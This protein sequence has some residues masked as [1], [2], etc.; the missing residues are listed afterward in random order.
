MGA[1]ITEID[2]KSPAARAKIRPGETLLAINGH[3][4]R[5]VLDY[6]FYA[7]DARLTLELD[8]R[9]VR[10]RKREGEDL[11]LNFETYLMD[12]KK[13]CANRCIF[14][15]IDQLPPGMRETL[16][17][18]D[19]DAR[20]SFLMGNYISLTNLS[21]QDVE[22]IIRMRLAPI[23]ISVQVTDPET[24]RRML[25]NPRAGECMAIM[26]RFAAAELTLN[27]QLVICPGVNDGA[28]LRRSLE[29]LVALAPAV[30][31]IS[32]VPVGITRY[33]EGLC[34][35]TPV[36]REKA[37]EII[38]L[39]EEFGARCIEQHGA[40]IVF[41]G[42]ELYIK[43]QRP[44]PDA[45]FYEEFAQLENGVGMMAL[46][47]QEFM[48]ALAEQ[49]PAAP[50]PDFTIATGTSAAP[51]IRNLVDA[52]AK[53]C[54]NSFRYNVIAVKNRFFGE[55]VNVAGLVTGRDLID[56]LRGNITGARL[57][58]PEVMLRHE[59]NVF[60]DDV[61]LAQA[62]VALG[63]PITPLCNDGYEMLARITAPGDE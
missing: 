26:K 25:G 37:G 39:V 49:D 13:R 55:T 7:Y 62:E 9:T 30:N 1:K 41:C 31:S 56:A 50:I 54:N 3:T 33:R 53:R 29:E 57:F 4:I 2:K 45:A 59:T 40:R 16:Y 44:I 17:F 32:V 24:R 27:C 5:D 21:E 11:G 22:R 20:M 14:C 51:F 8:T 18:K 47:Q 43:A 10:I 28:L 19:D 23:N 48:D 42:D 6:K 58:I 34:P 35:L 61:T 12:R 15:F 63:V 52:L 60:L 38:D 46:Q 36:N